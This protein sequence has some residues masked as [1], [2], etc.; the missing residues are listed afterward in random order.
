MRETAA[1]PLHVVV[2]SEHT[3]VAQAVSAA[4]QRSGLRTTLLESRQAVSPPDAGLLLTEL[5]SW[6]RLRQ[7]RAALAAVPTRWVVLTDAP[8]GPRWGA[9]LSYGA[10]AVLPAD[11]TR[12]MVLYVLEQ[13]AHGAQ[14]ML[15]DEAQDLC[16][17][18]TGLAQAHEELRRRFEHLTPRELA[19][20]Q[21]LYRGASPADAAATLESSLATVRSQVKSILRKL[22]VGTQIAAVVA[23][24]EYLEIDPPR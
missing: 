19:V 6:A 14:L 18:W 13:A 1:R 23:L 9:A 4:L 16:D 17:Q 22:Q 15:P 24:R 2:S 3:V 21:L 11:A 8:S 10:V 20:L 12:R 7:V 5:D